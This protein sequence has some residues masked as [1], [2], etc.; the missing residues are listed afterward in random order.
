[1]K[2]RA[3]RVRA[4]PGKLLACERASLFR[5]RAHHEE[6]R[7]RATGDALELLKLFERLVLIPLE[8]KA[9]INAKEMAS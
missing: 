4:R 6:M 7:G 5:A 1:M 3:M 8:L 2:V 9:G